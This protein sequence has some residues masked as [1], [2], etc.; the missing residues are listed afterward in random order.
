MGDNDFCL[1]VLRGGGLTGSDLCFRKL[2][3][4]KKEALVERLQISQKNFHKVNLFKNV[5]I[6]CNNCFEMQ[7]NK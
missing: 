7:L 6:W 1:F 5:N 3:A 4:C 2:V